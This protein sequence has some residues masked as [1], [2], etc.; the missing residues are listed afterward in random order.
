[1]PPIVEY[2]CILKIYLGMRTRIVLYF[3][4][5]IICFPI[6]FDEFRGVLEDI[7]DEFFKNIWVLVRIF[8]YL[9]IYII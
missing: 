9:H 6:Y 8:G 7:E 5:V 2:N 4:P 1:M 3:V